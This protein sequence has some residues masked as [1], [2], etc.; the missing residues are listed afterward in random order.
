MTTFASTWSSPP[1]TVD[2]G[3]PGFWAVASSTIEME[4][5]PKGFELIWAIVAC[6]EYSPGVAP[7]VLGSAVS[8]QCP[9]LGDDVGADECE[10]VEIRQLTQA[11]DDVLGPHV[12]V[13]S[14]PVLDLRGGLGV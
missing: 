4:K 14:E 6:I 2:D 5:P 13:S 11:Y 3:P 7:G 9:D 1:R 8:R 12:G 10:G